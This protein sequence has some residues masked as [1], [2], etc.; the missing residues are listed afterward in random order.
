MAFKKNPNFAEE[1]KGQHDHREALRAAAEEVAAR[2]SGFAAQAHAP[3]MKRQAET[4]EVMTDAEGVYVINTDYAGHLLE[5]G[6]KNNPPHAILRRAVQ[7]SGLNFKE[8][9]KGE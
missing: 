6:S 9:S 8:K 3:W 7:A 4:I 5:W 2:A 1:M